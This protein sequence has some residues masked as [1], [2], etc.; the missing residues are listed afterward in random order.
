MSHLHSIS[1]RLLGS[2]I[3]YNTFST[4]L[5]NTENALSANQLGKRKENNAPD[6]ISPRAS[7]PT[8]TPLVSEDFDFLDG[9]PIQSP[10]DMSSSSK[11]E[12]SSL[13][14]LT[15]EI[16]NEELDAFIGQPAAA[17]SPSFVPDIDSA[18]KALNNILENLSQFFK[19]H[20]YQDPTE[21]HAR[22]ELTRSVIEQGRVVMTAITPPTK[23]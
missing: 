7:D 10:N 13:N 3:P 16:P 15:R 5:H 21:Q 8:H 17:P 20:P 12:T 4:Y 6:P 2:T 11:S 22:A 1:S 14:W 23:E 19:K 9:R 18:K